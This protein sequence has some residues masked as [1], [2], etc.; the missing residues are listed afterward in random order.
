MATQNYNT[1]DLETNHGYRQ[2]FCI[3]YYRIHVRYIYR[4]LVDFYGKCRYQKMRF[5]VSHVVTGAYSS[6]NFWHISKMERYSRS[7]F[8]RH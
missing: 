2:V 5:Q 3:S 1:S 8:D 6:S 7:H 4:H